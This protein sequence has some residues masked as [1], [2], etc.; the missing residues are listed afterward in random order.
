MTAAQVVVTLAG[1]ALAIAV[2]LYFF[3]PRRATRRR[4]TP[5][6][7]VAAAPGAGGGSLVIPGDGRAGPGSP[8]SPAA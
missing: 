4:D 1:A 3:A 7:G 2:N 6:D 5:R 8:R